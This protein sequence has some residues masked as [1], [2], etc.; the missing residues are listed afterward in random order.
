MR[1]LYLFLAGLWFVDFNNT[2]PTKEQFIAEVYHVIID[3]SKAEFYLDNDCASIYL[4][5]EVIS[6]IKR[7]FNR[8]IPEKALVKILHNAAADTIAQEWI[9]NFSFKVKYPDSI[10]EEV[11]RLLVIKNK[12]AWNEQVIID[13]TKKK[14]LADDIYEWEPRY[15]FSRPIFD[16][17][18]RYAIIRMSEHCG[19]LCGGGCIYLF[20]KEKGKW[21]KIAQT[22]CWVS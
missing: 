9:K 1:L 12:E 6:N 17:S 11:N 21:T 7:D 8:I 15:Y 20:H 13:R 18:R 19:D 22:R 10:S 16:E 2:K 3:T 4:D 5:S 14:V